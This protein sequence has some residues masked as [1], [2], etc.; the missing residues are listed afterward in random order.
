MKAP[1]VLL[2]DFG[3]SDAYV[4]VMK[5]VIQNLSPE[6]PVIDL[7]H[8]INPQNIKHARAILSD[9]INYFN[10]KSIFCCVIDPEVGSARKAIA[11]ASNNRILIGPDNGLFSEFISNGNVFELPTE[12]GI[13]MTFHGRDIFAPWAAKLAID[14][15]KLHGLKIL[16]EENLTVLPTINMELDNTWQ[17]LEILYHDHFGN[18]IT[19]A[20]VTQRAI[21]VRMQ[22]QTLPVFNHYSELPEN[23][24]GVIIGSSNRVELSIKNGN[25]ALSHS[26][27]ISIQARYTS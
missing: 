6:I 15:S 4:G 18:L 1:I 5:G 19:N 27:I 26:K 20:I 10:D 12:I 9:N 24:L 8:N 14:R 11:V 13:S 21:E 22:D 7:C 16:C 23:T 3:L 17:T 25:A 2:S